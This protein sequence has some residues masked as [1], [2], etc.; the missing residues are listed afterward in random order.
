MNKPNTH[1]TCRCHYAGL[2]DSLLA[3]VGVPPEMVI[4]MPAFGR[5]Y[6]LTSPLSHGVG[7]VVTGGASAAPYTRES[8]FYSYY[9][10]CDSD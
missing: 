6:K 5:S 1:K 2:G 4:G 8:M 10:M 9:E 3:A 7:A